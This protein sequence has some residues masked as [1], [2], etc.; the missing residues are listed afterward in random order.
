MKNIYTASGLSQN[1][2]QCQVLLHACDRKVEQA[3]GD[4][5]LGPERLVKRIDTLRHYTVGS[6]RSAS[7]AVSTPT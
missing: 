4:A 5:Y 7:R 1:S 2:R 3:D 6:S